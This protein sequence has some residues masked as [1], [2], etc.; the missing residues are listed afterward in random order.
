MKRIALLHTV[1]SVF[2]SFE[3]RIRTALP[4]EEL[5]IHNTLDDFLASDA[6][7]R[8]FTQNN[9]N[10]LFHLLKAIELE[11]PDVIAVTCSTLTP[12]VARIRPFL[13]VP[14]IAIDDVM[15]KKAVALGSKITV[16]A[17]AQSTVEPT[18]QKLLEE[19]A[20][21]GGKVELSPMV[22]HD[23]Y[24]AIKRMD[25]PAH[26]AFLRKAAGGI[27]DQDVVVL[28]QASMAHMENEL[29]AICGIP[30]LSSPA[31]CVEQIVHTLYP[32]R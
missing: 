27:H 19:A 13:S 17:T 30:V 20:K 18:C 8:G 16:M 2:L 4:G 15:A 22:C 29:A 32:A 28:A 11:E 1:P 25:Q 7:V 3:K 14:L 31:L 5:N 9:R 24:E 12:E 21:I 23:A 6:N 26:D 10:R